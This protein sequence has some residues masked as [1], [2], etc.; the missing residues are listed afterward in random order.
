MNKTA[1]LFIA[2]FWL[3]TGI[4]TAQKT[5]IQPLEVN[6]FFHG[7]MLISKGMT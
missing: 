4:A 1:Y 3:L 2:T 5:F 6:G 7:L